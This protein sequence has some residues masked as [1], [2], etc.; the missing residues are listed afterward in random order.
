ME[1]RLVS[2]S[3]INGALPQP[4]SSYVRGT[5]GRSKDWRHRAGLMHQTQA[6]FRPVPYRGQQS[7]F[8]VDIYA[9]GVLSYK[10]LL[11]KVPAC[12]GA[13]LPFLVNHPLCHHPQIAELRPVTFSRFCFSKRP[14]SGERNEWDPRPRMTLS[15]GFGNCS[16]RDREGRSARAAGS[17]PS[18]GLRAP[19]DAI[20]AQVLTQPFHLVPGFGLPVRFTRLLTSLKRRERK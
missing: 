13:S 17:A 8:S 1:L 18:V 19:K 15:L 9:V 2:G 20:V 7:S 14:K 12:G 3:S 6:G 4:I 10:C 11:H 5:H 16:S